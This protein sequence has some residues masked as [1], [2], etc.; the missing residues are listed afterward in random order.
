MN[1]ILLSAIVERI[2]DASAASL[3]GMATIFVVLSIIWGILEI[4]GRVFGREKKITAVIPDDTVPVDENAE[5]DRIAAAITVAISLILEEEAA[6][7]GEEHTPGF[8]VVSFKRASGARPWN[9][10]DKY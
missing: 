5:S 4:F 10:S 3:I 9:Q 8:R 2:K 1:G 7:K 6:E